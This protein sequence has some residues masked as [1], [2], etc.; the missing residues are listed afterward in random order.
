MLGLGRREEIDHCSVALLLH[1][2]PGYGTFVGE[3]I[4]SG[5]H[6]NLGVM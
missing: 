1:S 6:P 3:V 4:R 2:L 5:R